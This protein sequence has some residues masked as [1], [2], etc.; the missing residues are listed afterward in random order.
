MNG[1]K[2]FSQT[3]VATF[4]CRPILKSVTA[5]VSPLTN[6]LRR[7]FM[8]LFRLK[9]NSAEYT[10]SRNSLSALMGNLLQKNSSL[11]THLKT[12][13]APLTLLEEQLH[14]R[15]FGCK[16]IITIGL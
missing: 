1:R 8:D 2:H 14:L 10:S 5:V 3:Q 7:S 15:Y 9:V 16:A 13:H 12:M 6:L 11:L 4:I